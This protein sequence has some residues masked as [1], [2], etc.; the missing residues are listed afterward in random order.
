MRILVTGGT[1]FVGTHTVAA[2]LEAGHDVRMLVRSPDLVRSVLAPHGIDRDLDV[3]PGDVTEPDTVERAIAGCN[4]VIHGASVFTLDARRGDLMRRVNVQGTETVLAAAAR[5]ELD[6]IVHVSSELSLLPPNA[7]LLG[8]ESPVPP[9]P[10]RYVYCHTK[11]MSEL[12][13]RRF[14]EEGVPVVSVMPTSLW[15]PNDPHLGEGPLLARNVLKRRI[16]AVT[17]GGLQIADVRDVSR[18]LA[19][20]IESGR[21][22]RS[23]L[24]AGHYL[25]IREI[26]RTLAQL[27]GRRFPAMLVPKGFMLGVASVADAIQRRTTA[28]MPWSRESVWVVNQ[29]ARCHDPR[30]GA[31]LGFEPRPIEQT[32]SDTVRWLLEAGHI[33]PKDA[34]RLAFD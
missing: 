14:Q 20:A 11:G 26:L 34:G 29:G 12:V 19:A 6:P 28:R 31:D 7:P 2:L 10:E 5:A 24:L 4:A 1:G 8:P 32:F 21:G 15:G 23:Y 27:T 9:P 13:A 22:P 25:S 17:S 18:A 33:A 30:A 16:P 3:V